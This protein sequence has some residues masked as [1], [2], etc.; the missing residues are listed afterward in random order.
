MLKVT[1]DVF[2]GRENPRWL[3]DDKEAQT[4]L[5]ELATARDA[6]MDVDSGPQELG[7]RGLVVEPLSDNLTA[8]YGLPSTFRIASGAAT[9]DSKGLE[10]AE[11]LIKG[12]LK[13]TP[14]SMTDSTD[15]EPFDKDLQK[16]LLDQL[17]TASHATVTAD[18]ETITVD[19]SEEAA[20]EDDE[21]G[22]IK[23]SKKLPAITVVGKAVLAKICQFES[24]MFNPA[25]WNAPAHVTK[26]NCYN[27]ASNRRTDTFAQPGRATGQ[28]YSALTCAQVGPAAVRDGAR[29]HPNCAPATEN[30]RWYMALVIAPGPGF[31]DYHW[32]RKSKEGFWGHKPGGT[33][34][35]N[36]DNSGKI[37]TDPRTADRGPYTIFCGFYYA[38]KK[39]VVK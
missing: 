10:V 25:F 7:Y 16:F 5:K 30:P 38:Q 13:G 19:E 21:T 28:Q 29:A 1:A 12:M 18:T 20:A 27:Y 33:P 11:R 39:M 17:G 6:V 8:E 36:T 15:V 3:V 4:V 24:G 34:A 2:S 31:K 37:I 22:T 32:Y 35:R 23:A 9:F 26:N 14:L